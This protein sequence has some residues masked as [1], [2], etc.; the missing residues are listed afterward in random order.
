MLEYIYI[1]IYYTYMYIYVHHPYTHTY[2]YTHTTHTYYIYIYIYIYLNYLIWYDS[3]CLLTKFLFNIHKTIC[4]INV[5]SFF[6]QDVLRTRSSYTNDGCSK[7]AKIYLPF[8]PRVSIAIANIWFFTLQLNK[9]SIKLFCFCAHSST[10]CN[11]KRSEK[12]IFNIYD[13][14]VVFCFFL[15]FHCLHRCC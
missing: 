3:P 1:Y 4:L 6:C 14:L 5:H 11:N 9:S 12:A 2:S 7:D 13:S 8:K 10:G 15:V